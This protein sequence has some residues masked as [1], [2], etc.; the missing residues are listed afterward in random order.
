MRV[1]HE[2][3]ADGTEQPIMPVGVQPTLDPNGGLTETVNGLAI[4]DLKIA[5]PA[6]AD[7]YYLRFYVRT[8]GNDNND[9]LSE[10]KAFATV[11]RAF[12]EVSRWNFNGRTPYFDIG[13][14]TFTITKPIKY[15]GATGEPART[16]TIKGADRDTTIF[17]ITYTGSIFLFYGDTNYVSFQQITFKG[18]NTKGNRLFGAI[19][20]HLSV[21]DCKVTGSFSDLVRC[22]YSAYVTFSNILYE[23]AVITATMFQ[24]QNH[25]AITLSGTHNLSNVTAGNFIN[26]STF[27]GVA[28]AAISIVSSGTQPTRKFTLSKMSYINVAGRGEDILP[29]TTAGTK[30]DSSFYF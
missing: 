4:K 11:E 19:G 9:G 20:T 23:D 6:T 15:V 27:S 14:G 7:D 2:I 5:S 29:G 21:S 18:N 25:S 22:D 26:V 16:F 13:A 17:D 24:V 1:I 28:A 3:L 12:E 30:D 10:S 8:N